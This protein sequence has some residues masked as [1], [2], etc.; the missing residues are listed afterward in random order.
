MCK[1]SCVVQTYVAQSST[2]APFSFLIFLTTL[3]HLQ[4]P[5]SSVTPT[6]S[7]ASLTQCPGSP[8]YVDFYLNLS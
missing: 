5:H 1:W 8:P 4:H 3:F 6:Q 7:L 2:R